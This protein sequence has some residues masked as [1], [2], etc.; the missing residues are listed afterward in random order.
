MV[1]DQVPEFH[2]DTTGFKPPL[3]LN[4]NVAIA[5]KPTNYPAHRWTSA[6]ELSEARDNLIPTARP[7]PV[8][9]TAA[10]TVA[11]LPS[12][13]AATP[14][15]TWQGE[16][17][18]GGGGVERV[19]PPPGADGSQHALTMASGAPS[20]APRWMPND[21]TRDRQVQSIHDYGKTSS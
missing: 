12:G 10:L 18:F 16:S 6:S 5:T 4:D 11:I 8:A 19:A 20:L 2:I 3:N 7:W 21:S 13:Q 9:G 1:W 14:Y 15:H 17:V